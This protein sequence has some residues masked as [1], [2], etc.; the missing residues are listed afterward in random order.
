MLLSR[1][2][3]NECRSSNIWSRPAQLSQTDGA[4]ERFASCRRSAAQV[5]H[6]ILLM[7][8]EFHGDVVEDGKDAAEKRGRFFE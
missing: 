1:R 4:R 8:G 6:V 3:S 5:R 7:H 2:N